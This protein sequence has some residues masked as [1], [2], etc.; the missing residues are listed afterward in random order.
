MVWCT[1]ECG[2]PAFFFFSYPNALHLFQI[3]T[4]TFTPL[5]WIHVRGFG[6]DISFKVNKKNA[7]IQP[8]LKPNGV[9]G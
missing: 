6:Y 4:K 2:S 3:F 5:V 1:V 8:Q 7:I 9:K